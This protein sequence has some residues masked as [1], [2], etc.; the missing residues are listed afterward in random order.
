MKMQ[1]SN[2]FLTSQKQLMGRNQPLQW[3]LAVWNRVR[4]PWLLENT[5]DMCPALQ[6]AQWHQVLDS[7]ILHL[8]LCLERVY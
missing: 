1:T 6:T 7:I 8:H 2:A 4:D 5:L 3:H